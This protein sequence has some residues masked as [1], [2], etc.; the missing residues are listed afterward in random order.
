MVLK[1][2]EINYFEESYLELKFSWKK[3]IQSFFPAIIIALIIFVLIWAGNYFDPLGENIFLTSFSSFLSNNWLVII[4]FILVLS[5]W[6]YIFKVFR[7]TKLRYI[8]P[9]FDS[10]GMFFGFWII[11]LIFYGLKL[12]IEATELHIFFSFLHDF[13][14]D[15][16]ILLFCLIIII[17]YSNFFLKDRK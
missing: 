2:V 14:Y 6:E 3:F 16:T 15:Q 12:F 4:L 5:V 8:A 7:K 9:F 1:L 10:V 17:N 11:A 13:F